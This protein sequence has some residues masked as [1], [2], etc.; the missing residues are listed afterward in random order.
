MYEHNR[1]PR[2]T[3]SELVMGNEYLFR[4]YSENQCG[5][6]ETPG[7]STNTAVIPKAGPSHRGGDTPRILGGLVDAW[8]PRLGWGGG[9]RPELWVPVWVWGCSLGTGVSAC[10][11]G[12]DADACVPSWFWGG[13]PDTGVPPNSGEVAWRCGSPP[14]FGG[15][16]GHLGPP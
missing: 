5:T 12:G 2:C 14:D 8:D 10:L 4:V 16:P 15:L 13:T 11:G 7:L 9:G 1:L 3:V 6:S